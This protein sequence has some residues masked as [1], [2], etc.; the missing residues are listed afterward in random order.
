TRVAAE[1]LRRDGQIGTLEAGKLAD[2]IA[3]DHDPLASP[4]RI[5]DPRT[6]RL[7]LKD[8]SVAKDLDRR[9]SAV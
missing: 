5:G 3:V 2:L 6:V 4:D 1:L 8:G 7:V 9:T